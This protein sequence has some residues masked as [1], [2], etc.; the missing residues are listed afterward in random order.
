M[1]LINLKEDEDYVDELDGSK[2]KEG[3]QFVE[4]PTYFSTAPMGQEE[5]LGKLETVYD[6]KIEKPIEKEGLDVKG[7]EDFANED[8][9]DISQNPFNM[10]RKVMPKLTAS[11]VFEERPMGKPKESFYGVKLVLKKF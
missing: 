1:T 10:I 9:P 6:I 2:A 5:L 7:D 3:A 11:K 8:Q 4:R